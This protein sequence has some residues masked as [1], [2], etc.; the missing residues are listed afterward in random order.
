VT[1]NPR[2]L[3]PFAS[4]R[5]ARSFLA[6]CLVAGAFALSCPDRARAQQEAAPPDSVAIAKAMAASDRAVAAALGKDS[7]GDPD[8]IEF[9]V[10]MPEDYFDWLGTLGYRRR[11]LSDTHFEHYVHT[12]VTYGHKDYLTEGSASV[13]WYFRPK[14]LWHP[15]WKVR[16]VLEGGM[17]AH[18]VV[19]FADLV[20]LG[21]WSSHARAFAK[22]HL[23][24]GLET[25][26]GDRW[27]LGLRGR[28]TIPAHRPLDYAQVVLFL[29]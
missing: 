5:A 23:Q 2:G 15:E 10:A 17:G 1:V 8:R 9:G 29:R 20:G 11:V 22:T 13:A 18:V 25:N 14:A 7:S 4:E 27:G 12:E 24:A 19:Q 6:A 3:G 21:D 16:P 28:L 26:L